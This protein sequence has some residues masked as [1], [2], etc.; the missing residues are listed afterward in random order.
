MIATLNFLLAFFFS[1][2]GSIP[3]GTINLTCVQLG[4]ERK[5]KVA[6]RFAV[7]ASVLEYPFGW[8]AVEFAEWI[9]SSPVIVEN[10]QLITGI[11]MTL[12]GILT[13]W[14][15]SRPSTFTLK[16]S[17]NGYL[18]GV[19]L[20][21]LNPLVIP[22]WVGVT[23]Y[24]KSLGWIDLSTPVRLHSYLLGVCLGTLGLLGI[25]IYL[26]EKLGMQFTQSRWLYK[27]PGIALIIL[28]FYAFLQYLL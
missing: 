14:T 3:P 22:F 15:P 17:E 26:A 2:I 25:L 7:T 10:M 27:V 28:G 8:I 12:I 23:A 6:W 18:R 5:T 13:L 11:A 24:L 16:L 19:V 20:S 9:T 1:F 21:L 4:L